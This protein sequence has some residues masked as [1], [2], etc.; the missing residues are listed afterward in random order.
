MR[1]LAGDYEFEPVLV[2]R[3]Q[4]GLIPTDAYDAGGGSFFFEGRRELST[5]ASRVLLFERLEAAAEGRKRDV[6]ALL[7]R[8]TPDV[9]DLTGF[10]SDPARPV[11]V[12]QALDAWYETMH[13]NLRSSAVMLGHV[14]RE[15]AATA[16][17][18]NRTRQEVATADHLTSSYRNSLL[19]VALTEL[20]L[21]LKI[22]GIKKLKEMASRGIRNE[23]MAA[24]IA[25]V[26][27]LIEELPQFKTKN[28]IHVLFS[29][30]RDI[31]LGIDLA[32]MAAHCVDTIAAAVAACRGRGARVVLQCYSAIVLGRL[33]AWAETVS[34]RNEELLFAEL[35]GSSQGKKGKKGKNGADSKAAA[36]VAEVAP[37]GADS[38][39]EVEDENAMLLRM[40]AGRTGKKI[41]N[42]PKAAPAAK[43]ET[44]GKL[45]VNKI[46]EAYFGG[47]E[48]DDESESDGRSLPEENLSFASTLI[49]ATKGP[50]KERG[51]VP[52]RLLPQSSATLHGTPSQQAQQL[53]QPASQG[54]GQGQGIS[55]SNSM[56]KGGNQTLKG[57]VSA[58]DAAKAAAAAAAALAS[59]SISRSAANSFTSSSPRSALGGAAPVGAN[60]WGT[61]TGA[62]RDRSS[63]PT[64]AE[65]KDRRSPAPVAPPPKSPPGPTPTPTPA[66]VVH[67]GTLPP[68]HP[69]AAPV[70]PPAAPAPPG[71]FPP[72]QPPMAPP[73]AAP[74]LHMF[75]HM[76]QAMHMLAQQAQVQAAQQQAYEMEQ[77]ALLQRQQEFRSIAELM[78]QQF[79]AQ[80]MTDPN[81]LQHQL[82]Q[83]AV[84]MGL[85]QHPM[86]PQQPPHPPQP[87][88]PMFGDPAAAAALPPLA[89]QSPGPVAPPP[90]VGLPPH[91]QSLPDASGP[92]WAMLAAQ[93]GSLQQASAAL[94]VPG[95]T[96]QLSDPL[97]GSSGAYEDY[98]HS[99]SP[100]SSSLLGAGL[101]SALGETFS[102]TRAPVP[103]PDPAPLDSG[104][105]VLAALLWS[106]PF[107]RAQLLVAD[108]DGGSP[109]GSVILSL[110]L[111]FDTL[112]LQ[113]K[114]VRL[115][116]LSYDQ[117][118]AVPANLAANLAAR[119][120]AVGVLDGLHVDGGTLGRLLDAF[121][122]GAGLKDNPVVRTFGVTALHET[123]CPSCKRAV[124]MSQ[125]ALYEQ[126][127]AVAAA[128]IGLIESIKCDKLTTKVPCDKGAGGCGRTVLLRQ[129]LQAPLPQALAVTVG[130]EG[131]STAV[132]VSSF[133]SG[134]PISTQMADIF[135]PGTPEG[136]LPFDLRAIM[137][138]APGGT[139]V[140][141]VRSANTIGSWDRLTASGGLEVGEF[142]AVK[143]EIIAGKCQPVGL[144]FTQSAISFPL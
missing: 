44:Q 66:V 107:F 58:A 1:W 127:Y 63:T 11:R 96:P 136:S 101:W 83:L 38:E 57:V 47:S 6:R 99:T 93:N 32:E 73:S 43:A 29:E 23:E 76:Q 74:D 17:N 3:L 16:I 24:T 100:S 9:S 133:L 75:A 91:P 112:D 26:R 138:R 97:F 40:A 82:H 137:C 62:G 65:K 125:V 121:K 120:G 140:G 77:M 60:G 143:G 119:L 131:E 135:G 81:L 54:Q 128:E 85:L 61:T 22:D 90:H 56:S 8:D 87:I 126:A 115:G 92:L 25:A 105:S 12:A 89:M 27:N 80:G 46:V 34:R 64:P 86:M 141:Y 129:K 79:A 35:A 68:L 116:I 95:I 122:S 7:G 104:V 72:P 52:A 110:R 4:P 10:E 117:A 18:A 94:N 45:Y 13:L 31:R 5:A 15:A 123:N 2:H 39:E 98:A 109:E 144:I 142:S 19:Q 42:A 88:P 124:S 37:S 14:L 36:A 78:A 53:K 111:I 33:Q 118:L 70:T 139:M 114:S 21:D 108:A 106:I 134:V 103:A 113:S 55:R 41:A 49:T 132:D 69:P 59:I 67:P 84:S 30:C 71:G 48:S 20:V 130:W 102:P 50:G 28:N 51:P